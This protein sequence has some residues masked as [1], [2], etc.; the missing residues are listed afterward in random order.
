MVIKLTLV[1]RTPRIIR[2]RIS[3]KVKLHINWCVL[4]NT[5]HIHRYK[6]YTSAPH[7][8]NEI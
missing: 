6:N 8:S 3:I 4:L 5:I 2:Y 7:Q 1:E